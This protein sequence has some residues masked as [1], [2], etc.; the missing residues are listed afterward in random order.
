MK[1]TDLLISIQ[2]IILTSIVSV[3][4]ILVNRVSLVKEVD[5]SLLMIVFSG[6]VLNVF[7]YFILVFLFSLFVYF[8][9]AVLKDVTPFS[10]FI[11]KTIKILS[12]LPLFS[13]TNFVVEIL[14]LPNT[15]IGTLITI[16]IKLPAYLILLNSIKKNI[17]I[18]KKYSV[19]SSIILLL[20]S[21]GFMIIFKL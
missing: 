6:V 13:I 11:S 14:S 18:E 19:N 17:C 1:R 5:L 9:N 12:W 10:I 8:A 15:M 7:V 20:L 16:I 21:L 3:F 4:S 2:T